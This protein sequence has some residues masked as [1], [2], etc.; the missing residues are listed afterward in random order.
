MFVS[1]VFV[2]RMH[3]L[4]LKSPCGEAGSL[5]F[6][7]L[8][9]GSVLPRLGDGNALISGAPPTLAGSRATEQVCQLPQA[10]KAACCRVVP[11]SPPCKASASEPCSGEARGDLQRAHTGLACPGCGVCRLSTGPISFWQRDCN[12]VQTFR[13]ELGLP[14]FQAGRQEVNTHTE[15]GVRRPDLTR[16]AGLRPSRRLLP[17]AAK[18]GEPLGPPL[19]LGAELPGARAR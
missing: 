10:G 7:D 6:T 13:L 2:G 1:P 16:A 12:W 15:G 11:V 9:T 14:S 19:G 5:E 4:V 17:A 8:W 18:D 3:E